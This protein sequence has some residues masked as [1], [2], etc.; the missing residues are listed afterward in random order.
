MVCIQ[1]LSAGFLLLGTPL[2]GWKI[3]PP[4][5]T[6]P[7]R[8]L[9]YDRKFAQIMKNY[10]NVQN[11][12]IWGCPC[13][14]HPPLPTLPT[15]RQSK[16][17]LEETLLHWRQKINVFHYQVP[18]QY[19]RTF[20]FKEFFFKWKNRKTSLKNLTDSKANSTLL[21]MWINWYQTSSKNVVY[22]PNQLITRILR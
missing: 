2:I 8:A 6:R 15:P 10:Q 1:P 5:V 7:F 22:L 14:H 4:T 16:N 21:S 12:I 17:F 13:S 9:S 18:K 20:V 3:P 11:F 19:F